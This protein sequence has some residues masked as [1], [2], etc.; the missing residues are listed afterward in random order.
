MSWSGE[1]S[2][3]AQVGRVADQVR[4]AVTGAGAQRGI[5][6]LAIQQAIYNDRSEL[7]PGPDLV[8]FHW[9]ITPPLPT[10][11]VGSSANPNAN[12][13]Q[14][15]LHGRG[16]ES[17]ALLSTALVSSAVPLQNQRPT[18]GLLLGCPADHSPNHDHVGYYHPAHPVPTHHGSPL[19]QTPRLLPSQVGYAQHGSPPQ[20]SPM[21]GLVMNSNGAG[22]HHSPPQVGGMVA[23]VG[24]PRGAGWG[25][26]VAGPGVES[27]LLDLQGENERLRTE[28]E[29]EKNNSKCGWLRGGCIK[30]RGCG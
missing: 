25:V 16:G 3:R 24:T 11:P 23:P 15:A 21:R 20:S 14:S 12:G 9:K 6:T 27:R 28:W 7:V 19:Q 18:A 26:Q 10:A 22:V 30:L 5:I 1:E 17:P 2:G 4:G 29:K 13:T 8:S